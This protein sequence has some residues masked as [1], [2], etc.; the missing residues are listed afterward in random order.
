VSQEIVDVHEWVVD[1]SD[2]YSPLTGADRLVQLR[3][4]SVGG[5]W[6]VY[7]IRGEAAA[8]I[9]AKLIEAAGVTDSDA[10]SVQ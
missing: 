10:E 2:S 9:G 8:R 6:I 1:G 3:L 4:R 7:G 5:E